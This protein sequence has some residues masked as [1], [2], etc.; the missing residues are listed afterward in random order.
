M[1][2]WPDDGS[3]VMRW[4]KANEARRTKLSSIMLHPESLKKMFFS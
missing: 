4:K 2:S 3:L 1:G